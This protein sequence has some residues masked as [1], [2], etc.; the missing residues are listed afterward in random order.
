[1]RVYDES[2]LEVF[3]LPDFITN[4][5][6]KVKGIKYQSTN[7]VYVPSLGWD[8]NF[9]RNIYDNPQLALNHMIDKLDE[10]IA[11]LQ[12]IKDEVLENGFK[13]LGS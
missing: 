9:N 13:S 8:L 6:I 7:L 10:K 2:K 5:V 11:N 4:K 1:M 3:Y 12:K